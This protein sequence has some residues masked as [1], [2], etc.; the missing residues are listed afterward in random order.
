MAA[1]NLRV[2]FEDQ[3]IKTFRFSL[4]APLG[5][6]LLDIKEKV[7]GDKG[8]RDH[9]LFQPST[10]ETPARWLRSNRPLKYYGIVANDEVEYRKK[11]KVMTIRLVDNSAKSVLV[12]TSRPVREVVQKV[13]DK[14]FLKRCAEY[15]LRRTGGTQAEW[16]DSSRSIGEHEIQVD[17]LVFAKRFFNNDLDVDKDDPVQLHL[18]YI[19]A[20]TSLLAGDYEPMLRQELIDLAA[21]QIQ[22]VTGSH[23]PNKHKPGFLDLSKYL[24]AAWLKDKKIEADLLAEHKR[25]SGMSELDA[26][27]RYVQLARVLKNYGR[28]LF[29]VLE[30]QDKNSRVTKIKK[31]F[32][33]ILAINK[34]NIEKWDAETREVLKQWPLLTVRRWAHTTATLALEF[35]AP[36]SAAEETLFMHTTEGSAITS[37]I[38]GYID[39]MA[40]HRGIFTSPRDDLDETQLEAS[41]AVTGTSTITNL[42][43][44]S[45]G[46]AFPRTQQ[47]TIE[48]LASTIRALQTLSS[49]LA[50]GLESFS[51]SHT[52]TSDQWSDQMTAYL[53]NLDTDLQKM[54]SLVRSDPEKF[55]RNQADKISRSLN[56]QILGLSI[57]AKNIAAI[58]GNKSLLDGAR[59]ISDAVSNLLSLI[60][61]AAPGMD[62]QRFLNQLAEAEKA[63]AAAAAALEQERLQHF[64]D[65][66][67]EVL[68]LECIADV[69]SGIETLVDAAQDAA[70]TLLDVGVREKL[71]DEAGNTRAT[72]GW[73][74]HTLTSLAPVMVDPKIQGLVENSTNTI[75]SSANRL[76]STARAANLEKKHQ[77]KIDKPLKR[78][79][80]SI[81]LLLDVRAI[82]ETRGAE[83]EVDLETPASLLLAALAQVR[84]NIDVPN[85]LVTPTRNAV[86]ATNLIVR[87]T[88]TLAD[89][90]DEATQ[91]R[92]M[93]AAKNI[94]ETMNALL[95]NTK[96]YFKDT[97]NMNAKGDILEN[98]SKLEAYCQDILTDAGVT[99]ALTALRY[100]AKISVA[101]TIKLLNL[102]LNAS[103]SI[104]DKE[105]KA[106]LDAIALSIADNINAMIVALNPAA[107]K[108]NDIVVQKKLMSVIKTNLPGF[109]S[110][111]ADIKAMKKLGRSAEEKASLAGA[112]DSLSEALGL[113]EKACKTVGNIGSMNE[114]EEA[115]EDFVAIQ[116]DLDAAMF[117]ADQGLLAAL[118]GQTRENALE[119]LSL[120][121]RS[122]AKTLQ[123]MTDATKKSKQLSNH[124][125]DSAAASTELTAAVRVMAS[126]VADRPTQRRIVTSAK[127]VTTGTLVLVSSC[128]VLVVDVKNE[129]K[130]KAVDVDHAK[131]R[132]EL[133]TL[134]AAAKGL[135]AR[136]CDE[137]IAVFVAESAKL[138]SNMPTAVT[139]KSSSDTLVAIAKAM[140]AAISQLV[141]NAR[142]NPRGVGSAAKITS[143]TLTQLVQAINAAASTAEE[144]VSK[145]LLAASKTFIEKLTD[146]MQTI[147]RVAASRDAE[148]MNQLDADHRAVTEALQ[149]ILAALGNAS[150]PEA[151]DAIRLIMEAVQNLDNLDGVDGKGRAEVLDSFSDIHQ[152]LN[153]IIHNLILSSRDPS[154]M[155]VFS[156]EA[157]ATIAALIDAA[158]AASKNAGSPVASPVSTAIQDLIKCCEYVLKYPTE[159]QKVAG[160]TKKATQCCS[161]LVNLSKQMALKL[162]APED[163]PKQQT[164]LRAAK[165]VAQGGSHLAE[166]A[167]T[168]KLPALTDAAKALM[169][170]A[171]DLDE[172]CSDG[173][174][175]DN[176][177]AQ[178]LSA[179]SRT[180]GVGV[181]DVI[182]AAAL[183][184]SNK[185]E[186][187][188]ELRKAH[189]SL[190]DALNT[191]AAV[192]R[193]LNPGILECQRTEEKT[194]ASSTEMDAISLE[195]AAGTA[196]LANPG[197]THAEVQ[198]EYVAALKAL[199]ADIAAFTTAASSGSV[200]DL[201]KT[202]KAVQKAIATLESVTRNAVATSATSQAQ[203]QYLNHTKNVLDKTL[204]VIRA[205]KETDPTD[206]ESIEPL[207]VASDEAAKTIGAILASLQ[208]N[209][210]L[211]GD[212][213]K[214]IATVTADGKLLSSKLDQNLVRKRYGQ[215]KEDAS[216]LATKQLTTLVQSLS[217]SSPDNLGQLGLQAKRIGDNFPSLVA[218]VRG[219]ATVTTD[220]H[221]SQEILAASKTFADTIL[222]VLEQAKAFAKDAHNPVAM[223][224][225]RASNQTLPAEA[226]KLADA[227][228]RGAVGEIMCENAIASIQT[229]VG[230]INTSSIFA[231]RIHSELR[232]GFGVWIK[233]IFRYA[234]MA[235]LVLIE[236]SS[237]VLN[238]KVPRLH[239][240]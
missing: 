122:L 153:A 17:E 75:T 167:T 134:L 140:A 6:L 67:F 38:A 150:S 165:A 90:S 35:G 213:D 96:V 64:A 45:K 177:S 102:S 131:V 121:A 198:E 98:A 176:S 227:L 161:L 125:R 212:I 116:V 138:T 169:G 130:I 77:N 184:S 225:L 87:D 18:V 206:D 158:R 70:P 223:Q 83:G 103:P 47:L 180:V 181:A 82:V 237:E 239:L 218:A 228:R 112:S 100:T 95:E 81:K 93:K 24:P 156:K 13:A 163:K 71:E 238:A 174:H 172:A 23:D 160:V 51:A 143:V 60:E 207:V 152:S 149:A 20:V 73:A 118:P 124:V 2:K 154:K 69:N 11:H 185:K 117:A 221:A 208:S 133:A 197:K 29:V 232:H 39:I 209:V 97:M 57:T 210:A 52:L 66:G 151:D 189:G 171:K 142:S 89:V 233:H 101:R 136:E 123:L 188:G 53:K 61:K 219:A 30:A 166:C 235:H 9:G 217:M 120:A 68:M 43:M 44:E 215:Y 164:I 48:G 58:T 72:A 106:K 173:N 128:R 62:V 78:L 34:E 148:S 240:D 33:I 141:G 132:S 157:A 109:H 114:I 129:E 10:K 32:E 135:D 231:L 110:F 234:V 108:P 201:V 229:S 178:R 1:I 194:Q 159:E 111:L 139:F 144:Q 236:V 28:T 40:E 59:N 25:L 204:A 41:V 54:L 15:S 216:N 16:L 26:K 94:G 31:P 162:T 5:D 56:A 63:V 36:G 196:N 186:A 86:N 88:K 21:V 22:I 187:A 205:G 8:A 80:L 91:D 42:I 224:K 137:A 84:K 76:V 147:K 12:D 192:V 4:D 27:Y 226:A 37:L 200:D 14:I 168:M 155:G 92:L 230:Q 220:A 222:R 46:S 199:G 55:D 203:Q 182:R 65:K 115:L 107:K 50:L 190:Q 214:V 126:T 79:N 195:L 146:L 85:D 191:M 179:S 175:I 113:L 145:D 170:F 74:V 19:Q 202:A 7:G 193:S 119:M 3:S 105:A 127:N 104:K 99:A 211:V 183:V 49:E